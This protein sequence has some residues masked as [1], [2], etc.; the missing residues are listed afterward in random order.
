MRRR[1]GG[2]PE[3]RVLG[4]CR[5]HAVWRD[6]LRFQAPIGRRATRAERLDA[7]GI[8]P[9]HGPDTDHPR[10]AVFGWLDQAIRGCLIQQVLAER[11]QLESRWRATRIAHAMDGNRIWPAV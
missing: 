1:R 4:R 2:P 7:A 6:E 9:R 8:L 3:K 10:A 5:A 11:E